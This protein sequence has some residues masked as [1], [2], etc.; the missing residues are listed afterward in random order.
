MTH[1]SPRL[2][3]GSL[4][5]AMSELYSAVLADI[6]D[7]LGLRNQALDGSIRPLY[8]GAKL[9]GRAKTVLCVEVFQVPS[10][11]YAREIEAVDTVKAGDV[12]VV[13]ADFRHGAFWG[14]LLATATVARGGVGAVVDGLCRDSGKLRDMKF[15]VFCKGLDP[16]DSKGR[17][18]VVAYDV[19]IRCGGVLIN[20]GDLVFADQDGVVM[21]PR[22]V[23]GDVVSRAVE[24][25]RRENTM[26]KDL[27]AGMTLREA[28]RKHRIL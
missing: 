1:E 7:E 3:P 18:D 23:V 26:R 28:F 19:P 24:K 16:C 4:S 11:P 2:R 15:P 13:S 22:E 14:E 17:L 20:P 10:D 21:I 6:M 8:E 27:M 5:Q 9:W 12:L 25:V